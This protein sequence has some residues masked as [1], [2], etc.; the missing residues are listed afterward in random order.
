MRKA[1]G[2]MWDLGVS[3][4]RGTK[5]RVSSRV[6]RKGELFPPSLNP[7]SGREVSITHL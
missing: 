4:P 3:L 2:H 1:V 6:K 5:A 7:D